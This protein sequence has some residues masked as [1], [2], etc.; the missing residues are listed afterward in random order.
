MSMPHRLRP[1]FWT[2]IAVALSAATAWVVARSAMPDHHHSHAP[3]SSP[4]AG[5]TFHD[6]LHARLEITPEQEARLAA[7]E[8]AYADQRKETAPAHP[9]GRAGSLRRSGPDARRR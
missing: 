8:V 2:A 6:W 5:E 4:D 9:A 3:A 1:L 7:I